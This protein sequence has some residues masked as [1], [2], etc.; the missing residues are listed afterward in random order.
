[1]E[2]RSVRV[3]V[4][5]LVWKD[6]KLV[7]VKRSKAYGNGTWSPPGGH[8]EF[9]ERI[10]DAAGRETMEEAGI[11]IENLEI[12]G[13][14]EDITPDKHYLTAWVRADWASGDLKTEDAEFTES[15]FFEIGSLPEDLFIS[16]RNLLDGKMIPKSSALT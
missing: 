12:L 9:G 14:T 4:G 13:F 10:L 11:E 16:F 7:L 3:G 6:G 2:E 15:G 1:M 5:V 8:L